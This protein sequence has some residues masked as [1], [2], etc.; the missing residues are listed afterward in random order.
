MNSALLSSESTNLIHSNRL[1]NLCQKAKLNRP[2]A[3]GRTKAAYSLHAISFA[4]IDFV[5]GLLFFRISLA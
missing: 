2:S 3:I 1:G 4:A 5:H